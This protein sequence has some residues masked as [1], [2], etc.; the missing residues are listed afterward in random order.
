MSD[1]KRLDN[2][3]VLVNPRKG[4][5]FVAVPDR[6]VGGLTFDALG[7]D[8]DGAFLVTDDGDRF[9]L[10]DDNRLMASAAME[11]GVIMLVEIPES[12][13]RREY[14]IRAMGP[15]HGAGLVSP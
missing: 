9:Y 2:A 14:Q 6:D 5:G 15:D 7:E 10:P 11:Q 12:G 8:E 13:D 1:L 4:G 3:I